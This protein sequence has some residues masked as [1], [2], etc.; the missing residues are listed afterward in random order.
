MDKLI[1]SY[2]NGCRITKDDITDIEQ[3]AV[4]L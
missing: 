3:E 4:W 2:Y 1:L